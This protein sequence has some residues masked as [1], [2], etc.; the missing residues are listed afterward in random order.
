[1]TEDIIPQLKCKICET[2]RELTEEEI[3]ESIDTI[4][5]HNMKPNQILNIWSAFDGDTCPMGGNHEYEWNPSFREKIMYDA[6]K[7]KSN[8]V[9]IVRNNNENEELRKNCIRL[10]EDNSAKIE[11]IKQETEQKIKEITDTKEKKVSE[12]KDKIKKNEDANTELEATNP[13]IE[14]NIMKTSG[15]DWRQ[16][17]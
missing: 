13:V 2:K 9:D 6:D 3:K 14:E 1:M 15:R 8:E 4:K 16:W 11:K 10:E 5:K 12:I 17:L 7:R